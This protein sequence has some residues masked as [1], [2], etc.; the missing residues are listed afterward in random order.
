MLNEAYSRRKV[1]NDYNRENLRC[2]RMGNCCAKAGLSPSSSF[3]DLKIVNGKATRRRSSGGQTAKKAPV[4]MKTAVATGNSLYNSLYNEQSSPYTKRT[5]ERLPPKHV[6]SPVYIP[7]KESP[8]SD[9]YRLRQEDLN[10]TKPLTSPPDSSLPESGR[11]SLES[12]QS[13][14]SPRTERRGSISLEQRLLRGHIRTGSNGHKRTGSGTSDIIP[15][16]RGDSKR[17]LV[18]ADYIRKGSWAVT[19]SKVQRNDSG[20]SAKDKPRIEI[21][22]TGSLD[23][24][25]G[26]SDCSEELPPH[27]QRPGYPSSISP[28]IGE[29]SRSGS[30]KNE[31]NPVLRSRKENLLTRRQVVSEVRLETLDL[32]LCVDEATADRRQR[33]L[34][35]S[36]ASANEECACVIKWKKGNLLG[37]GT[38]GMVSTSVPEYRRWDVPVN[39]K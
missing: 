28:V 25:S 18:H 22:V 13:H 26:T 19:E 10:G 32:A 34:S 11:G 30:C 27:I 17:G 15:R 5:G 14:E 9:S 35:D 8:R 12:K 23:R 38:F 37:K 16:E 4:P 31:L 29:L 6:P 1:C 2:D 7:P 24:D 20:G 3:Q 33:I 39:A 36:E 21:S